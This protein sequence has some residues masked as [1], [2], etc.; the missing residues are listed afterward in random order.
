MA[1]HPLGLIDA[2]DGE[3]DRNDRPQYAG[4]SGSDRARRLVRLFLRLAREYES[5]GP[6]RRRRGPRSQNIRRR[7][8]PP[9]QLSRQ[10]RPDQ[11][12]IFQVSPTGRL[13]WKGISPSPPACR[14]CSSKAMTESSAFSRPFPVV[15][16]GS[17]V[18]HAPGPGRV[19][20]LGRNEETAWSDW[21]RVS[22]RKRRAAS[23]P[24]SVRR[25][26]SYR[27]GEGKG[28]RRI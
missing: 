10:R 24:E 18:P 25:D 6:G 4:D 9:Q 15:L 14:R 23:S 26:V 22:S 28:G 19:S 5:P 16:E 3:P 11:V 13:P 21:I 1:I 27:R 7:L 2:T 8:L 17:L 12:G 20:R